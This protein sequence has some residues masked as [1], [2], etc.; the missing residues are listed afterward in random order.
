MFQ[1]ARTGQKQGANMAQ[2]HR[3]FTA[4][5]EHCLCGVRR[6]MALHPQPVARPVRNILSLCAGVGGLELGILLA[7][8]ALGEAG[9][10]ICYVERE[11][12]AAASLVASMEAGWFHH[13][14]VWSDML[15]FDARPWAG[16]VHILASGDPCQDN[17]VAG[18]RAGADGERFLAAEVC[19]LAAECRPDLVFR[20]NV[21]G[22]ADGQL[23]A[24]VPALERLGYRVAAGIFS[25]AETGNTMRRERL[26]IMAVRVD[27]RLP[28]AGLDLQQRSVGG[29]FGELCAEPVG[30]PLGR[31][32]GRDP[33][34][35]RRGEIGRIAADWAGGGDFGEVVQPEGE[36]PGE[37]RPEHAGQQGRRAVAGA[38]G[39]VARSDGARS[40]AGLPAAPGASGRHAAIALDDRGRLGGKHLPPAVI[41]GPSDS[42]W[43]DV[44]DRFPE[45]QP[46]LSQEE[47]QSHLRRGIDAMAHRVER[48]R[49]T[50]N[51]VD[52]VVAATAFLSLGAR[53][54]IIGRGAA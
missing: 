46:A 1:I 53:L 24:I 30:S 8:D 37:G 42:R 15:T 49:A 32:D 44:L 51:G 14:P 21:P 36:R 4:H 50:G 9:R 43:I 48:L 41:P 19:R 40:E 10:G 25:S 26:F 34:D 5:P 18:K 13:A 27:A 22:N 52:P 35:T 6:D 54:G 7:L 39:H 45:L 23:G 31:G 33:D 16:L 47:A 11:A 20:E 12:A 29:E 17:S 28:C 2:F 3:S 38:G